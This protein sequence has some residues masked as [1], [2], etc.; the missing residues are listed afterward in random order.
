MT[1][2]ALTA[3]WQIARSTIT[4]EFRTVIIAL[5]CVSLLQLGRQITRNQDHLP[6]SALFLCAL[7]GSFIV[8]VLQSK[9]QLSDEGLFANYASNALAHGVNPYVRLPVDTVAGTQLDP[10]GWTFRMDGTHVQQFSYPILALAV[11]FVVGL[12]PIHLPL[13]VLASLVA[14]VGSACLVKRRWGSIAA[15]IFVGVWFTPI[16]QPLVASG[17]TDFLLIPPLIAIAGLLKKTNSAIT[18]RFSLLLTIVICLKQTAW[19]MTPFLVLAAS[20]NAESK[21]NID[22]LKFRNIT[23]LTFVFSVILNT[24]G[25]LLFGFPT[26]WNAVMQPFSSV[27]V[28]NGAGLADLVRSYGIS[29][30]DFLTF[31]S[32]ACFAGLF[33]FA[34]HLDLTGRFFCAM[35]STLLPLLS[36][37][38]FLSYAITLAPV[39]ICAP[40]ML[41]LTSPAGSI[42]QLAQRRTTLRFASIPVLAVVIG[43][44]I[45]LQSP[46]GKLQISSLEYN[47]Q[48]G[49]LVSLRL[50]G[51]G[52]HESLD[53]Y[54]YFVEGSNG[55]T[56]PWVKVKSAADVV[57][58]LAP[59]QWAGTDVSQGFRVIA[60]NP[61]TKMV[62]AVSYGAFPVLTV[63]PIRTPSALRLH[64]VGFL[65]FRMHGTTSLKG[66]LE[67]SLSQLGLQGSGARTGILRL[68]QGGIGESSYPK[69]VKHD[70]IIRFSAECT[71]ATSALQVV[72]FEVR[73]REAQPLRTLGQD[74]TLVCR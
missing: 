48:F 36:H 69:R 27:L 2:T 61:R 25:G 16:F 63:D 24:V 62:R 7:I 73:T 39:L 53:E 49:K 3:C 33:L 23:C 67:V 72:H 42:K 52:V 46:S 64:E 29:N 10:N 38:G 32:M 74:L 15:I 5:I 8:I 50:H 30:I 54:S 12:L 59:N 26:Y 1:A 65:Y 56:A 51:F 14:L 18:L 4:V 11:Y 13:A 41:R 44:L 47:S 70:G 35:A 21:R 57:T 55:L 34:T 28:P 9:N 66:T 19:L 22:W 40:D 60:T 20:T 68:D 37:R 6:T 45:A 58:L 43:S 31:I 71:Q 17:N